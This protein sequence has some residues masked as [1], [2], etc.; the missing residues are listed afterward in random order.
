MTNADLG[1]APAG[2]G[3]TGGAD[4][5][6]P[7]EMAAA[8]VQTVKQEAAT[9]ADSA[10]DKV[11]EQVGQKKET[12][13]QTLGDFANAIRKA[14]DELAQHDQSMAGRMVKQAADGLEGISRSVSDKRPEELLEAVREFGRANPTAFIAG[15]VLLGLA[16]G[17]FA[18]SSEQHGEGQSGSTYVPSQDFGPRKTGAL[19]LS[20][21]QGDGQR[22]VDG[23]SGEAGPSA[24]AGS[25]SFGAEG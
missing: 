21:P 2:P 11:L 8:A 19:G 5:S 25:S 15:S 4:T 12:A 10:K 3:P 24:S 7:K 18:R 1:G 17:R 13:S 22:Q 23:P 16:I 20:T 6:S 9:F 14:G